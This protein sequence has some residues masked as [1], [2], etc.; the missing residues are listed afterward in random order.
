MVV[1]A[2]QGEYEIING[3]IEED[4]QL[5]MVD[6]RFERSGYGARRVSGQ[7]PRKN[8]LIYG[9]GSLNSS[10]HGSYATMSLFLCLVLKLEAFPKPSGCS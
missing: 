10:I 1:C 2:G 9:L 4:G 6:D 8:R 5:N 3:S 7:S